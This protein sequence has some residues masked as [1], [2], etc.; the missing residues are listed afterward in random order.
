MRKERPVGTPFTT[1]NTVADLVLSTS[2]T[3]SATM[4]NG[5]R[6]QSFRKFDDDDTDRDAP[7]QF[8]SPDPVVPKGTAPATHRVASIPRHYCT[9]G[10]NSNLRKPHHLGSLARLAVHSCFFWFLQHPPPLPPPPPHPASEA[11]GGIEIGPAGGTVDPSMAA[12]DRTEE[13][14]D[15]AWSWVESRGMSLSF[16]SLSDTADADDDEDKLVGTSVV[17]CGW[18]GWG[19]WGGTTHDVSKKPGE[20]IGGDTTQPMRRK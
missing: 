14:S 5:V 18:G 13:F 4:C 15:S 12:V 11:E 9:S 6:S 2:V 7:R 1:R 8:P 10:N 16:W 3:Y 20:H 19:G 17:A